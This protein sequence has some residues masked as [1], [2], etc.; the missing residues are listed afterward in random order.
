[1]IIDLL[2]HGEVKGEAAI[3]RGCGTDVPL[4]A[5]GWRQMQAVARAARADG[6]DAVASSSLQRCRAFAEGFA[7]GENL[8]L[9][10]LPEMREIDFGLWEG[11]GEDEIEDKALLQQFWRDPSEVVLP[12]GEAVA[13]F[14]RRIMNGWQ[15]WLD[16]EDG[17]HRLLV[18]HGLVL[19]LLL[20]R[21]LGMPLSMLWRLHLPYAAWSRLQLLPGKP[22]QLVFMNR[23]LC[24]D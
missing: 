10:I 3:A 21:L 14:G 7:A 6:V 24:A 4:T 20:C 15:A 1:M 5:T 16:E 9:S 13:A 11:K 2:R 12:G 19:R 22:P 18:S 17:N 8:S 23:Q